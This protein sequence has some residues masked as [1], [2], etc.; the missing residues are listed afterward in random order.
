MGSAMEAKKYEGGSDDGK[1]KEWEDKAFLYY[2]NREKTVVTTSVTR[3]G[4]IEKHLEIVLP[5]SRNFATRT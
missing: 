5:H 2:E 3:P 1:W 4:E